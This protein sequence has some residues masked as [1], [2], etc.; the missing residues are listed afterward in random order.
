MLTGGNDAIVDDDVASTTLG[1][2]GART[3]STD[4]SGI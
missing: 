1:L 4:R 3:G 2:S